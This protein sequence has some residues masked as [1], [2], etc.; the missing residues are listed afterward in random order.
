MDIVATLEQKSRKH[1][2]KQLLDK[3]M[4]TNFTLRRQDIVKGDILVRD[5]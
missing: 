1:L 4:Q 3:L 2:K 5:F